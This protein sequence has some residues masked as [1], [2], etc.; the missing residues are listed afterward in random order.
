MDKSDQDRIAGRKWAEETLAGIADESADYREGFWREIGRHQPKPSPLKLGLMSDEQA[1]EFGRRTIGF[2]TH[3]TKRY[4]DAPLEYLKWLA[5]ANV[6][7]ARYVGS[8]RVQAETTE[9]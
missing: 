6:D 7:L 4:D 8:R 3:G 1:R 9:D 2:G 5:E